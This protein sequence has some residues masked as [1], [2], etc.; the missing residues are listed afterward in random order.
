M[1]KNEKKNTEKH[2]F[3]VREDESVRNSWKEHW[4]LFTIWNCSVCIALSNM[5]EF[6]GR[7]ILSYFFPLT[8]DDCLSIHIE[9]RPSMNIFHFP[10]DNGK[11]E[12]VLFNSIRP[13]VIII[14]C[15]LHISRQNRKLT[16]SNQ[17]FCFSCNERSTSSLRTNHSAST[18]TSHQIPWRTFMVIIEMSYASKL[19]FANYDN[20]YYRC[21]CFNQLLL[22][23][24]SPNWII[25]NPPRQPI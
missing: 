3:I 24:S 25:G 2:L 18:L 20:Y 4:M 17:Y 8:S 10:I 12:I 9:H 11:V 14:L 19:L 16:M 6:I 1:K 5:H 7:S 22:S 13:M 23:T 21:H 15:I